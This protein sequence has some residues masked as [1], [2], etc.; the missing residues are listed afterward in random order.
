MVKGGGKGRGKK[1]QYLR[2]VALS[3]VGLELTILAFLEG[4]AETLIT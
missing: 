1:K 4:S 3:E 2:E